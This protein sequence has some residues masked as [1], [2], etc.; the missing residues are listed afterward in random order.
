MSIHINQQPMTT[1][2]IN[3]LSSETSSTDGGWFTTTYTALQAREPQAA[4]ASVKDGESFINV[5]NA[6]SISFLDHIVA[7]SAT[8]SMEKRLY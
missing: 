6:I 8:Q 5:S 7:R 1:T 4:E 2:T 3:A